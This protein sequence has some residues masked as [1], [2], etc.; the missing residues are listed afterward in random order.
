ME[1]SHSIKE[2]HATFLD[3]IKVFHSYCVENGL[4]YYMVGGTLLGA[5]RENGFIPWDD[6]VDFAMPRPDYERFIKICKKFR[7]ESIDKSHKFLYPYAKVFPLVDTI[8]YIKD[9]KWNIDGTVFLSFD[10]YPLDGVGSDESL[11]KMHA[12]K[13]QQIRRLCYLNMT[14]DKSPCIFKRFFVQLL[15]TL[16]SHLLMKYQCR[17]MKKY[18]YNESSY[19]TRW[20]M[21]I[22]SDNIVPRDTFEPA[23]LLPF[24]DIKLFAPHRFDW[25]L[26]KVYGEYLNPVRENI[27]LRHDTKANYLSTNLSNYIKK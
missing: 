10:L 16:P 20:R 1:N 8:M 15:R 23:V 26:R 21:P 17:L 14:E 18:K 27:G 9:D 19:V 11:A 22:L 4:T 24:E 6:D 3:M 2:L 5:A 13:V 25:Y 7:I 12:S